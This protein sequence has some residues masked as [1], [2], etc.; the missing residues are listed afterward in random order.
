MSRAERLL[1]VVCVT[2]A[3]ASVGKEAAAPCDC[4]CNS[5]STMSSVAI[6][7]SAVTRV[8][9]M[10]AAVRGSFLRALQ[11]C[12]ADAGSAMLRPSRTP[13]S[14]S[15]AECRWSNGRM[16]A[17]TSIVV[18]ELGSRATAIVDLLE[19]VAD[20]PA[21]RAAGCRQPEASPRATTRHR[22][23]ADDAASAD[24]E[25]GAREVGRDYHVCVGFKGR[26]QKGGDQ[27][28]GG[29]RHACIEAAGGVGWRAE[30]PGWLRVPGEGNSRHGVGQCAPQISGDDPVL[31]RTAARRTTGEH[32]RRDCHTS[33]LG[34]RMQ[35]S[36]VV[37]RLDKVNVP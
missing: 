35:V 28:A 36:P 3:S 33:L 37:D 22:L 4:G 8:A 34:P 30:E 1:L 19:E 17:P 20:V 2:P 21:S 24:V 14:S 9:Q 15:R 29:L 7:A 18:A 5:R 23:A 12:G 26:S 32:R 16:L 31:P 11:R 27:A 13:A 6:A 25:G 10:Q